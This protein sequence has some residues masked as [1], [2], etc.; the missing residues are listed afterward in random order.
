MFLGAVLM[1]SGCNF[2]QSPL[3]LPPPQT[4]CEE[5]PNNDS[6]DVRLAQRVPA[7]GGMFFDSDDQGNR[8]LYVYLTDLSQE[9]AVKQ[10]IREIFGPR[11][12]ELHTYPREIRVLQ[13][14]YSFLQLKVWHD[15]M[16]RWILPIPGVTMTD[17][18]DKRN[19]IAVGID[20]G[21]QAESKRRVIEA[22]ETAL[23]RLGIPRE[24]VILEEES[25]A[26]PK[27][28]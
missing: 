6:A 14:Q 1:L 27:S 20:I 18:D 12:V 15:C 3:P 22:V 19:R 4:T 10:A 8:I 26:A 28:Y 2:F 13:G 5:T 17:I 24:A 7:Y 11:W 9:E 21:L 25:P 16:R 23:E